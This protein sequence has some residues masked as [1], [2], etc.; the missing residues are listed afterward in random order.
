MMP[1]VPLPYIA[2]AC[3]TGATIEDKEA[4]IVLWTLAIP[5]SGLIL[6]VGSI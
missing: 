2:A 5:V 4:V 1:V 3:K 6:V